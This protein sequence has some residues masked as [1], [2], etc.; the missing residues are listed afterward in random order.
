MFHL[1]KLFGKLT[2]KDKTLDKDKIARM[3]KDRPEA[4]EAFEQAYTAAALAASPQRRWV[5]PY[6][7]CQDVAGNFLPIALDRAVPDGNRNDP[8]VERLVELTG[9]DN[10]LLRFA[11]LREADDLVLLPVVAAIPRKLDFVYCHLLG[12][13]LS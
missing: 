2:P 13:L 12:Y 3:L 11:V 5:Y 10:V 8:Q 6:L 1:E 7:S 9:D 4:L